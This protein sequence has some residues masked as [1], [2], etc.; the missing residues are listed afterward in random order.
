[1]KRDEHNGV[2]VPFPCLVFECLWDV[3]IR[4]LCEFGVDGYTCDSDQ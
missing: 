4:S 1:M 3:G 2:F